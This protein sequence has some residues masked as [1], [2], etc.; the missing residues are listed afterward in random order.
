MLI[1]SDRDSLYLEMTAVQKCKIEILARGDVMPAD[2][3]GVDLAPVFEQIV[4]VRPDVLSLLVQRAMV[5]ARE[6]VE[7]ISWLSGQDLSGDSAVIEV[8]FEP[9]AKLVDVLMAGLGTARVPG[10]QEQVLSL[11]REM[12]DVLLGHVFGIVSLADTKRKGKAFF[13]TLEALHRDALSTASAS[14]QEGN[15][16]RSE[17]L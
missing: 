15:T 16:S 17:L 6:V 10:Y 7:N 9:I 11:A 8:F 4:Q 12:T 14:F 5:A 3:A 13:L 1:F 2:L